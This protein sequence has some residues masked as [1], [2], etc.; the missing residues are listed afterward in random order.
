MPDKPREDDPGKQIVVWPKAG[1]RASGSATRES[2][3]IARDFQHGA[4]AIVQRLIQREEEFARLSRITEK[5]NYGLMLEEVLDFLYDE[6]RRV[7]PFNRIGFSLVDEKRGTVVAWWARSDRG[8]LLGKGYEAPLAGSSLKQ[9]L[10]S[11]RPR[12]INDLEA[13]LAA[14]PQ[15]ESTR[16]IVNE[17]IRSSL[18][19]PLIVQGKPV[20]FI[21]FASVEKHAYSTSHVA[22]FQQIAGQL[23]AIVEKGRLYTELAEQKAVIER[24]NRMMLQE[25][26]MARQVQRAL[27]PQAA[28]ELEGFEIAFDYEPVVQVG[29]DI[30]DIVGIDR[31]GALLFLGD[32]MGHGVPAALVMSVVKTA[33]QAAVQAD[34]DPGN[35]LTHVNRVLSSMFTYHFVTAA[36][37]LLKARSREARVALAGHPAPLLVA[38]SPTEVT[39]EGDGGLPLGIDAK[40]RYA[41]FAVRLDPGDSLVFYTDGTTE[42]LDSQ[43]RQYGIERLKEQ[44]RRAAGESAGDLL[45]SIKRDLKAHCGEHPMSDDLTL[46]VAKATA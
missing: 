27:I 12:I 32:A 13:Y 36:C 21:F 30:I 14:R 26:E 28:P 2:E 16:L 33:L 25:L 38:G 35:V 46:L 18:T 29:G 42:A 1:E 6:I 24:Q 39:Q 10:D 40:S 3:E 31:G 45:A 41:A 20:G 34:P 43:E 15:S 5:I 44:V 11:G 22:F 17:G 19:C 23:S 7:I 8:T 37:C 9:I 4:D